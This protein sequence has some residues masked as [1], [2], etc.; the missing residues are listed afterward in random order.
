MA[1]LINKEKFIDVLLIAEGTYPYIRGGVSTWIHDLING[2]PEFNFGV[3]FLGSRPEDYG[4]IKYQLPE[5]LVYLSV[6]YLFDFKDSRIIRNTKAKK[7]SFSYLHFLHKWFKEHGNVDIDFPEKLKDISFYTKEI[8]RDIFLRSRE[9]WNFIIDMY[10]DYALETP[11]IDYFWTIRNMHAPIFTVANVAKNAPDFAIVHSPSTGYAGF[12]ASLLS[13]DRKKPFILTE[14]GIYTRERKIDL[15]N[16]DWLID[17]RLFLQ[18]DIGEIDHIKNLWIRFFESIGRF[19]YKASTLI[20]SLFSTAREIQISYG[21]DPEKCIIVPNGVDVENLSKL[22]EKRPREIPKVI[23]LLGRVVPIKDVKTFIKAM[24]IVCSKMPDVEGWIVGP[25][26]EDPDYYEECK[27]LVETFKLEN[28]VKFLGFQNPKDIFP[29]TGILTLTSI[30]E[31]MPLVILE[32]FAAGVPCV[33]TDVGSCRQLIYGGLNEEDIKVGKAGEVVPIANPEKLAEAY[34]KL[35]EDENL[36]KE[37]QK[38]ALNRVKSFYTRQ[39]FL[40]NYRKI[41]L[42]MKENGRNQL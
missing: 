5:N 42:E 40:D 13:Y 27:N 30:S 24:R 4:E 9:S 39:Q 8:N 7:E 31:G 10:S 3:I 21:A 18:K 11:F 32:G 14:H 19:T 37:C 41:Y 23:T 35:L 29:K 25:T 6:D 28:N 20:I 2:L 12:L 34:I 38:A 1:E 36:W 16:T 33:A 15:L 17:K 26:D 22:I